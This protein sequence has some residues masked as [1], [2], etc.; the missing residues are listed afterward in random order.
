ME[1]VTAIA[2]ALDDYHNEGS[3]QFNSAMYIYNMLT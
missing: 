2:Q 3:M 1:F